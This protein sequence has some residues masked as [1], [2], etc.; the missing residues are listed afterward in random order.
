M[1]EPR[2]DWVE[3]LRYFHGKGSVPRGGSSTVIVGAALL[4]LGLI[5]LFAILTQLT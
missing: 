1:K 2:D 5:T 4:I 3:A